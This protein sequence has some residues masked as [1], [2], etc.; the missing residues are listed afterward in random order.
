MMVLALAWL[1]RSASSVMRLISA[2]AAAWAWARTLSSSRARAASADSPGD[3]LEAGLGGGLGRLGLLEGGVDLLG[4]ALGRALALV[5]LAGAPLGLLLLPI[6]IALARPE[7]LLALGDLGLAR[8]QLV[9]ELALALGGQ[10]L[11]GQL[12]GLLD[13]GGLGL[14]GAAQLR[15][16]LVGGG[17]GAGRGTALA[18]QRA[19]R[20]ADHDGDDHVDDGHVLGPRGRGAPSCNATSVA[21]RWT[22]RSCDIGLMSSTTWCSNATDTRS[23]SPHSGNV[24]S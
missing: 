8:A 22:G 13:L 17:G 7:G 4:L 3:L 9:V 18:E 5:E 11:A 24:R 1:S 16:R 12:G 20:R 10:L 6:E 19:Q 14:G 15:H 2:A 23:A 21:I